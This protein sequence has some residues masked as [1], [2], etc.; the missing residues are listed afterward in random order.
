MLT[1]SKKNCKNLKIKILKKNKK[2]CLEIWRIG[3]FPP[4]LAWI[5]A[6]VSEKSELMDGWTMDSSSADKIKQS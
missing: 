4:N 5:H 2:N 3:S 6:A 1:K